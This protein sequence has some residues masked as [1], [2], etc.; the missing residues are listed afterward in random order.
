MR[1][2]LGRLHEAHARN[3]CTACWYSCRGEVEVLY[4]PRGFLNSMHSFL[5][6]SRRQPALEGVSKGIDHVHAR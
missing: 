1:T 2:V 5:W 3:T 4:E 6:Q